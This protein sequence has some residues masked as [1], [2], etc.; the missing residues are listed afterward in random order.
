MT[1]TIKP[2]VDIEFRN[3]AKRYETKRGEEL[4][5]IDKFNLSVEGGRLLVI[6]GPSGCGKT[7]LLRLISE[8][9][10]ISDG[11]LLVRDTRRHWKASIEQAPALLPWR[12]AFQN[13][14]LGVEI[15]KQRLRRASRED[16]L[17]DDA[18]NAKVYYDFGIFGLRGFEDSLPEELSGGMQQRVSILRALESHPKMLLCD[19]PF[20]AIDYVARL[21]LST[22][23]K[24]ISAELACT[25]VFVTHNIEEAIF[26][27]D[28]I[29]VLS[30]RPSRIVDDFEPRLEYP[31]DAAKCRLSREYPALFDRIWSKLR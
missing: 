14:Y 12:T 9:E 3:V 16:R 10:P 25:T 5:V 18:L 8:V 20:S 22:R 17:D 15:R 28:R 2:G 6:I 7:T 19:E 27:A 23:F 13:A 30:K 31:E 26:L 4:S 1:E 21:E 11:T 24:R 29:I